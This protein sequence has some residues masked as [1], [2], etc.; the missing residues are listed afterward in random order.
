MANM[1][2]FLWVLMTVLVLVPPMLVATLLLI[3]G[4]RR[5]TQHLRTK[6]PIGKMFKDLVD[7]ALFDDD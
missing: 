2:E 4:L 1:K 3:G 6:I 7:W 5:A